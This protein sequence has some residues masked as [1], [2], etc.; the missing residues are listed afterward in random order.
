MTGLPQKLHKELQASL[1]NNYRADLRNPNKDVYKKGDARVTQ[2]WKTMLADEIDQAERTL[3]KPPSNLGWK[4]GVVILLVI[5]VGSLLSFG[6]PL[7]QKH[8]LISSLMTIA[9]G[10]GS[11]YCFGKSGDAKARHKEQAIAKINAFLNSSQVDRMI[12][13]KLY[14]EWKG[15]TDSKFQELSHET[16][17]KMKTAWQKDIGD[18]AYNSLSETEQKKYQTALAVQKMRE[19]EFSEEFITEYLQK[20]EL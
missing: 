14:R 13:F 16:Q 10:F 9:S 6:S 12:D 7:I 8:P 2:V 20:L 3:A 1:G 19:A 11:I 17:A 5:F 18:K 15:W 4:I